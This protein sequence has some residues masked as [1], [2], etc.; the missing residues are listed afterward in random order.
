MSEGPRVDLAQSGDV[1]GIVA[2]HLQNLPWTLN[3]MAGAGQV[4]LLYEGL[5]AD[6]RSA[7]VTARIGNQVVSCASGTVDYSGASQRAARASRRQLIRT[8]L[9]TRPTITFPLLLDAWQTHRL[10]ERLDG[11]FSFLL[12][13]FTDPVARGQ[14]LGRQTLRALVKALGTAARPLVVD[15]SDRAVDGHA[16]YSALGFRDVGRTSRTAILQLDK[17]SKL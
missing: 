10:I 2:L 11:E 3:S 9:V 15:V 13:W 14:G 6:P 1:E 7:V 5:I 16:A 4:R 8:V 12:T 17:P